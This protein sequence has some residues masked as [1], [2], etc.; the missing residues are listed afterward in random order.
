M[1]AHTSGLISAVHHGQPTLATA[2]ESTQRARHE[3]PGPLRPSDGCDQ[4]AAAVK[5]AEAR[6]VSQSRCST[7]PEAE[8]SMEIVKRS[9][10]CGNA[11]TLMSTVKTTFSVLCAVPHCPG[12]PF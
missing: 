7:P 3:R 6:V 5:A 10:T 8:G 4:F 2:C 12:S 1:G 9:T 11:S